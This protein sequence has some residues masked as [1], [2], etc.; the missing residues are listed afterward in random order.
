M[1]GRIQRHEIERVIIH[2]TA[3]GL[4]RPVPVMEIHRHIWRDQYE[5]IEAGSKGYKVTVFTDD[6]YKI[7]ATVVTEEN[8]EPEI[9]VVRGGSL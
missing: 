5:V 8:P 1:S 3:M 9:T 2:E 4:D 6:G 7:R